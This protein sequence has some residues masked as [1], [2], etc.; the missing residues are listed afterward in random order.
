MIF[1]YHSPDFISIIQVI[2]LPLTQ[3]DKKK[4]TY[5]LDSDG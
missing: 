3:Y 5:F 2:C 1:V 4:S